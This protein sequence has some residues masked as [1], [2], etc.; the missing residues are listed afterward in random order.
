MS[1]SL[2]EAVINTLIRND[3]TVLAVFEKRVD[4]YDG[5]SK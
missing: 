3:R 1:C 2:I 5:I 4:L